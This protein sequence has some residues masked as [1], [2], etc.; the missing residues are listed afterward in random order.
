MS[1]YISSFLDNNIYFSLCFFFFFFSK[2]L[3]LCGHF[4]LVYRVIF[5]PFLQRLG[6]PLL[7]YAMVYSVSPLLM[8][9][10]LFCFHSFAVNETSV[11]N[12]FLL[13]VGLLYIILVDHIK[14][15]TAHCP[16]F[17]E[18]NILLSA[19]LDLTTLG[20]SCLLAF[21]FCPKEKC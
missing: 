14:A 20:I 8:T 2:V 6:N 18:T 11:V 13:A 21:F 12:S 19:S 4:I 16:W 5:L 15:V 17:L 7:T 9:A 3:Y 1:V 10:W